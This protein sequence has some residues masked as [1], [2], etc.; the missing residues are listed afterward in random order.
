[1]AIVIGANSDGV[2]CWR[3]HVTGIEVIG[4]NVSPFV[5]VFVATGAD[6]ANGEMTNSV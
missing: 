5:P 6:G 2:Y 1:M 4:D 3:H